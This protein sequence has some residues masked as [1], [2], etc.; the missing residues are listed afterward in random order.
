MRLRQ[1]IKVRQKKLA[2]CDYRQAT[3]RRSDNRLDKA[4]MPGWS[5]LWFCGMLDK[6]HNEA[7]LEL[8][9]FQFECGIKRHQARAR[10]RASIVS[11]M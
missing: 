11:P 1:A 4:D 9:R 3:L 6:M 2:G 7:P 5:E 10:R 8:A